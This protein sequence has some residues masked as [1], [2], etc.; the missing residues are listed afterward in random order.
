MNTTNIPRPVPPNLL[1]GITDQECRNELE[2][3]IKYFRGEGFGDFGA[4]G[5]LKGW[6]PAE[7]AIDAMERLR[8]L[9]K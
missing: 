5:D 4:H 9:L 7:T 1:T 3:L 8:G 2:K 6:T